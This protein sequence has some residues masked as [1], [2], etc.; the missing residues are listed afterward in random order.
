M[1]WAV[2]MNI[3]LLLERKYFKKHFCPKRSAILVIKKCLKF[4]LTFIN[5]KSKKHQN[6]SC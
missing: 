4:F 3:A 5:N 6:F 1:H 2:Y